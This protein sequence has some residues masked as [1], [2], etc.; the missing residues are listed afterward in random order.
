MSENTTE[1]TGPANLEAEQLLIGSLL[2]EN[3]AYHEV[4][5]RLRPE[6][7]SH[8]LNQELYRLIARLISE[9]RE[10]TPVTIVSLVADGD[11]LRDYLG[12][13]LAVTN[14]AFLEGIKHTVPG[15]A[16][17]IIDL[18]ERRALIKATE[19]A[20]ALAQMSPGALETEELRTKIERLLFQMPEVQAVQPIKTV[21]DLADETIQCAE[22]IFE[23]G[24]APGFK[25]GFEPF[26]KLVGAMCPGD[27]IVVGGATSAGKTA[28]VQQ[29]AFYTAH[30]R[31]VLA[32]SL[33]MSARQWNDRYLSQL[34]GIPT[35]VLEVGPFTAREFELMEIAKQETLRHLNMVICDQTG[36]TVP[37]IASHA[38]RVKKRF[39]LDLL[40]IDHLQFIQPKTANKEGPA[41]V[42]EITADLKAIAKRLQVPIIL[43]S[44]LNRETN[45]R[46]SNRP[47]LSDLYGGSAIEKD[48]DT[49]LFVHREHYWL[50]R[51]APESEADRPAWLA[52]LKEIENEAELILAK[53]RRGKGADCIKVGFNPELTMFYEFKENNSNVPTVEAA[54][55]YASNRSASGSARLI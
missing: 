18:A 16:D 45:K 6:H 7:F 2:A 12:D 19:E 49:V 36:L 47:V 13:L 8:K 10:A 30:H 26:D 42:A 51:K 43:I 9:G 15:L 32:M 20:R 41:A 17:E 3:D 54:K 4:A 11:R 38:R 53:R 29:V 27:L 24:I 1:I 22:K 46:S 37:L 40:V 31:K 23:T 39:G 21:A 5:G 48:A 50:A 33:E 35:E 14:E 28:L 44:H 55:R 25:S 34:T 52:K